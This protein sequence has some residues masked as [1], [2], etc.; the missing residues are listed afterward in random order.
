MTSTLYL[1]SSVDADTD[2]QPG[3]ASNGDDLDVDGNDDDGITILT[4]LEKGLDA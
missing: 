3:I 1:G 2:G 4:S